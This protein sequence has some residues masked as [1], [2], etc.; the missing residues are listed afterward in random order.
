MFRQTKIIRII[1]KIGRKTFTIMIKKERKKFYLYRMINLIKLIKMWPYQEILK[2]TYI[3][4][5]I[6]M[7]MMFKPKNK[8]LRSKFKNKKLNIKNK[9]N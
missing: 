3:K 7:I 2:I 9:S 8:R 6:L 4:S 1:N 5:Q